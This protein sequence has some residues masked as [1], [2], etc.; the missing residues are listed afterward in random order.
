MFRS[1][2]T[3]SP[4]NTRKGGGRAHELT[5]FGGL[6]RRLLLDLPSSKGISASGSSCE[7]EMEKATGLTRQGWPSAETAR[8]SP[9]QQ[10]R[11]IGPPA[12]GSLPGK[13]SRGPKKWSRA[14][15]TL[16]AVPVYH[17]TALP[18]VEREPALSGRIQDVRDGTR[19][20][21]SLGDS[22]VSGVVPDL[23]L[24]VADPTTDMGAHGK[25]PAVMVASGLPRGRSPPNQHWQGRGYD[26]L[27]WHGWLGRAVCSSH[28]VG[29]EPA[30]PA[31]R[32]W[33]PRRGWRRGLRASLSQLVA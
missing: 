18:E 26:L 15:P 27:W 21:S 5:G 20:K 12:S 6:G 32:C 3:L 29:R 2:P 28:I 13:V 16:V 7:L 23:H 30:S 31:C 19:E 8:S 22:V 14:S 9:N 1:R 10:S 33:L 17:L 4:R 25:P 24:F 11:R